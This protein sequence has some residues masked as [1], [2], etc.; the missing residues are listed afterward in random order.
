MRYVPMLVVRIVHVFEPF[1]QLSVA[2]DLVGCDPSPHVAELSPQLLIDAQDFAR[3]NHV[4]KQAADDLMVHRRPHHEPAL[5]GTVARPADEPGFRWCR[6]CRLGR[7]TSPVICRNGLTLVGLADST[8]PTWIFNEIVDE[9]Q[10]CAL[11]Q[12]IRRVAQKLLIAGKRVAIP[13]ILAQPSPSR[14]P[15]AV[16]RVVDRGGTAPQVE[17]V[18]H[19]PA[20]S[21]VMFLGHPGARLRQ[22]RQ[23]ARIAARDTPKDRS[24]PPASSSSPC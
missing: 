13:Q 11:H 9:K 20:A 24:T 17:I 22:I 5:F 15:D 10:R 16:V 18:M 6:R 19:D 8:H 21:V 4:P 12:R 7:G 14:R 2:A 3:L 1:L 23:S